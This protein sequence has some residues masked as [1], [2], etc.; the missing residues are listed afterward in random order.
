MWGMLTAFAGSAVW[1]A[2]VLG[3]LYETNN[4]D[5]LN[6]D[7]FIWWVPFLGVGGFSQFFAFNHH[8]D[9]KEWADGSSGASSSKASG[10]DYSCCPSWNPTCKC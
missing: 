8:K 10:P 7:F 3:W 5:T 6:Q 4:A 1:L 2:A 9:L